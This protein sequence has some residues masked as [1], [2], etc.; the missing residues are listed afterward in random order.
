MRSN[1]SFAA[2][3]QGTSETGIR[4]CLK[5]PAVGSTERHWPL[6]ALMLAPVKARVAASSRSCASAAAEGWRTPPARE[7][8]TGVVGLVLGILPAGGGTTAVAVAAGGWTLLVVEEEEEEE[9]EA[10]DEVEAAAVLA[11]V[12]AAAGAEVVVVLVS[13]VA[14]G[15]PAGAV[16]VT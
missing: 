5:S 10:D 2:P 16:T 9:E 11:D 8:G 13:F 15:A 12:A 1:F 4:F 3:E 6:A 7:T 14:A